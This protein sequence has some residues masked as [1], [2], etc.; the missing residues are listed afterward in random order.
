VHRTQQ[1]PTGRRLRGLDPGPDGGR[2]PTGLAAGLVAVT[3]LLLWL[4]PPAAGDVVGELARLRPAVAGQV[5][6]PAGAVDAASRTRLESI[7]AQLEAATGAQLQVVVVPTLGDEEIRDVASRLFEAWGIGRKGKDDGVLFLLATGDRH[8]YVEVGYGLEAV[9]P[10]GR[11]GTILEQQVLP[12]MRQGQTGEAVVRGVTAL[13][14][15]IARGAA[16]GQDQ[17]KARARRPTQSP[18]WLLVLVVALVLWGLIRRSSQAPGG[19]A[20]GRGGLGG[21]GS[22]GGFGGRGGFGAGGGFGGGFGGGLSGGGGAG[23]SW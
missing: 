12:S 16:N 5:V 4:A 23:R 15:V 7:A 3:A 18:G 6:D 2:T 1:G 8:V 17:A 11:V 10:D 9:L 22:F 19:G 21:P 14:E 13:A 20:G